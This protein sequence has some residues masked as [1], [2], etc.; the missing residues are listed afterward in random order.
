MKG[1]TI[2]FTGIHCSGKTT[3]A[4]ELVKEL[5]KRDIT[6]VFLD[7][8][9]IRSILSP[10][11]GST[12]YE[13]YRHSIRLANVCY[14]I[15]SNQV[16]NIV[17][18]ISPARKLRSYA[19]TLIKHFIEIRIIRSPET[20]SQ[21]MKSRNIYCDIFYEKGETPEILVDADVESVE[22]SV[23]KIIAYLEEEKII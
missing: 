7:D 19:R 8:D 5:K 9:K 18:T 4:T 17:C 22:N 14:I 13:N 21:Q 3:I 12:K 2:W 15:T 16:L 11:L 23:K 6:F 1:C 10:D 20:C